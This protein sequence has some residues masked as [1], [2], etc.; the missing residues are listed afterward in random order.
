MAIVRDP[1][2]WKRFSTAVHLDEEKT[3][4]NRDSGRS[5][6]KQEQHRD[7][8]LSQQRKEKRRCKC[9]AWIAVVVV[10][11]LVVG[12]VLGWY[13]TIGKSLVSLGV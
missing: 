11:M 4:G 2:F 3:V 10:V 1:Y 7:D 6:E 9:I 12:V 5:L 13:F 8:W